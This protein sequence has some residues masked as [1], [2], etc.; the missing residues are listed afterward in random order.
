MSH[1]TQILYDVIERRLDA[2]G[3][4][5]PFLE[6]EHLA[7]LK[8]SLADLRSHHAIELAEVRAGR[9]EDDAVDKLPMRPGPQGGAL[10]T[11]GAKRS[12]KK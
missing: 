10:R 3:V 2:L 9:E 4:Q 8:Q 7:P 5:F 6:A 1:S 11:G 12:T